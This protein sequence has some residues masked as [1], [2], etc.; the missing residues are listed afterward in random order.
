MTNHVHFKNAEDE[1]HSGEIVVAQGSQDSTTINVQLGILMTEHEYTVT[2]K[3]PISSAYVFEG[4]DNGELTV[5]DVTLKE[6]DDSESQFNATLT[7]TDAHGQ[8]NQII[9]LRN[10]ENVLTLNFDFSLM[11]D[12]LGT[13]FLRN[14]LHVV[15]RIS[16]D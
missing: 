2:F 6:G 5:K 11:N 10:G 7:T 3:A 9:K 12:S 16:S 15:R 14:G 8:F 1:S 4:A 13:P